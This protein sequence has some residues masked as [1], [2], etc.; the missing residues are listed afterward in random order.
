MCWTG[1]VQVSGVFISLSVKTNA[2]ARQD[3]YNSKQYV[4]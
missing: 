3:L 1:I 2:H 4:V